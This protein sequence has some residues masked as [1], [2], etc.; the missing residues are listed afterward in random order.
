MNTFY[1]HH[2]RSSRSVFNPTFGPGQLAG[3]SRCSIDL[4][5]RRSNPAL[6]DEMPPVALSTLPKGRRVAQWHYKCRPM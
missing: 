6:T 1:E 3:L 4:Y 5:E 2:Q